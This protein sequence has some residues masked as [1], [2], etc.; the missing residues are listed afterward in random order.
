MAAIPFIMASSLVACYG[1][2][3]GGNETSRRS[4]ASSLFTVCSSIVG[5]QDR[6]QKLSG[7][8]YDRTIHNI[9]MSE[10]ESSIII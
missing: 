3:L 4:E 10:C 9:I 6:T 1:F 5:L 2:W 8:N 7:Y